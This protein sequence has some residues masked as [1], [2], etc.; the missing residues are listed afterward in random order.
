MFWGSID[1]K[2]SKI[3]LNVEGFLNEKKKE[4][5]LPSQPIPSIRRPEQPS[6]I[7]NAVSQHMF[8]Q[9]NPS[10]H[11]KPVEYDLKQIMFQG[12]LYDKTPLSIKNIIKERS[13]TVFYIEDHIRYK[14]EI[15]AMDNIGHIEVHITADKNTAE[16]SFKKAVKYKFFKQENGEPKWM[17]TT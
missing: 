12:K 8:P 9:P 2:A 7:S 16:I 3:K 6:P 5:L 11:L 15:R 14:L 13:I 4:T 10:S 1:S 17:L